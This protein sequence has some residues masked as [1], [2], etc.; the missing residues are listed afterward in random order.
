MNDEIELVD[1]SAEFFAPASSDAIDALLGRYQVARRHCEQIAEIARGELGGALGYFIEGNAGDERLHRSLYVD[2]LFQIEGAIGALNADFWRRV[3]ALTD[4]YD[5]MPQKRR[6]EWNQQLKHPLGVATNF[7]RFDAEEA[8]RAGHTLPK[9]AVEP[10]PDFTEEAVRPTISGLL[11]SRQKFFAERVD[12]IFRALSGEHVTNAPEAF[13]KRMILNY[14]LSYGS[15]NHDRAGYI[16]D[17]RAVIAKFMGRDEPR[18]TATVP[19]LRSLENRT[20]EWL[21]VDGGALRV[22]LYKKGTA[23][24]E[25]HPDMAWRLNCVLSQLYPLAIPAEFRQRPTRKAKDVRPLA[26]PL[27]FSV[28]EVLADGAFGRYGIDVRTFAFQPGVDRTTHA[29][30]EALRVL[31]SVGGVLNQAGQV[32]FEYDAA[33]VVREICINGCVPDRASHQF[34]PTPPRLAAI[35]AELAGIG[36]GD[37]VL[38]PS[39]GQGDLAAVLPR[40]RTTCVEISRLHCAVLQARGLR[41]VEADFIAWEREQWAAG[42]RFDRVVM[43]PPFADGRARL[44]LE[45]A[46]RL[47]RPGGRLVA[48]LPASMRDKPQ[49]PGFSEQWSQTYA[50][51]FADTSASV[52]ILTAIAP[53]H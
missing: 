34:Y 37:T 33:P 4:V 12:G 26:R 27:P 52:A 20:G 9:W 53:V 25:V 6:D 36:E 1:P 3:L 49:L 39:A 32:A 45:A 29:F 10:L 43:N 28:I 16:A 18:Y 51:E 35:A 15:I 44:H 8:R 38:E 2:K 13:G 17:L 19:L 23:H 31:E 30:K 21:S 22:R 7:T 48:I 46:A 41:T 50:G 11:A 5:C 42:V 24:L 14:M 47:V 40:E